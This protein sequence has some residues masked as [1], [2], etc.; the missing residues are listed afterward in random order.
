MIC[1]AIFIYNMYFMISECFQLHTDMKLCLA[2]FRFEKIYS[3]IAEISNIVIR[4]TVFQSQRTTSKYKQQ[5]YWGEQAIS[6]GCP[7]L[8]LEYEY[9]Y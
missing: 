3:I 6:F 7:A 2:S 8:C 5:T 1:P 4:W 9:Y